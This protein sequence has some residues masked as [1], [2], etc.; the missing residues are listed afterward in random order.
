[1]TDEWDSS[2]DDFAQAAMPRLRRLAYGWCRDWHRADDLVQETLE[3][4]YAAW[5]RL[6]RDT[7]PFAYART[8]MLRHL[9]SEQRRPWRRR[10]VSGLSPGPEDPVATCTDPAVNLDLLAAIAALPPR[11]R[12]VVLLRH[13]EDLSTAEVA[14]VLHCSEGTVKSQAHHARTALQRQLGE[15]YGHRAPAA[16]QGRDRGTTPTPAST[17]GDGPPG[18][19]D[20]PAPT[21]HQ[22]AGGHR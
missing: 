14:E 9:I 15:A 3:R 18:G 19:P 8:T 12:A 22:A 7:Q 13:V 1:M 5:P 11:Q 4:V 20:E 21:D 6:R 2:F 10:E 16:Q 17:R